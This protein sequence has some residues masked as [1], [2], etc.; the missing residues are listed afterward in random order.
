[1]TRENR[2]KSIRKAPGICWKSSMK[3]EMETDGN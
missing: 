1:M 3:S 2:L